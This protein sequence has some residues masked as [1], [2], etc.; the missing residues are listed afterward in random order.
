MVGHA[1]VDERQA[2]TERSM[3]KDISKQLQQEREE[4]DEARA[5]IEEM[6]RNLDE[7]Q[8]RPS[9]TERKL[10]RVLGEYRYSS[11]KE[12]GQD[13]ADGAKQGH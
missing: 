1:A 5:L 12:M 13:V 2:H 8:A 3:L 4:E 7:A 9:E 6:Q 10:G 11:E